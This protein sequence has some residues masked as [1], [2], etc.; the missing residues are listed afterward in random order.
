MRPARSPLPAQVRSALA[1]ND[2]IEAIKLLREATGLGLKEAK[3]RI[4]AERAGPETLSL[5]TETPDTLIDTGALPPEVLDSVRRG[6]KLE[7][8]HRLRI[9]TDMDLAMAKSLVE[10]AMAQMASQR[11]AEAAPSPGQVQA[12]PASRLWWIGAA[13]LLVM[14]WLVLR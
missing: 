9:R 8:I 13:G 11:E 5:D 4:D 6:N 3:D 14:A 12:A 7:A 1:R 2:T 10:A